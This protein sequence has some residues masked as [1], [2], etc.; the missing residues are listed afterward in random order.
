MKAGRLGR[1]AKGESLVGVPRGTATYRRVSTSDLVRAG[2]RRAS[3]GNSLDLPRSL[4]C[5]T[6][7]IGARRP[8]D[9]AAYVLRRFPAPRVPAAQRAA[10]LSVA[11]SLR[12][13]YRPP[14]VLSAIRRTDYVPGPY[15]SRIPALTDPL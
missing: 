15:S 2:A 13:D 3:W 4:A 14:D 1:R 6:R 7:R 12:S 10:L 9:L 5:S 11:R 8:A